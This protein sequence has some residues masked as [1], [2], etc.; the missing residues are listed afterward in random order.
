M[1]Y[2]D[3]NKSKNNDIPCL[4]DIVFE[5]RNKEYGAYQLRKK[6]VRRGCIGLLVAI[7]IISI[8]LLVP[9]YR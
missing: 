4:D 6:Y 9:Y 3:N 2:S 7:S 1:T 5:F 8:S